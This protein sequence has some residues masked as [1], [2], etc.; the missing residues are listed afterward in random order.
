MFEDY[1]D[2]VSVDELCDMLRCGRN[3]AYRFLENG[4]INAIRNGKKYIIPKQAVCNFI[5]SALQTTT[6]SDSA[7]L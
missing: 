2:I 6:L 3:A 5:Q 7:H 4:Q 1:P